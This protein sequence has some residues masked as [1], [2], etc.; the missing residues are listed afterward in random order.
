LVVLEECI[1]NPDHK[2]SPAIVGWP[3]GA[4][5]YRCRH[6]S[7]LEKHW[8]DAKTVI[9]P[10]ASRTEHKPPD[11]PLVEIM[12]S[13]R[14]LQDI[15]ADSLPAIVVHNN[16]PRTFVREGRLVRIRDVDGII[17]IEPLNESS[18]MG[19]LARSADFVQ[20][21][22]R[23]T[24]SADPP[25]KVVKDILAMTSWPDIPPIIGLVESP[26]IRPDGSVLDKFGYDPATKLYYTDEQK[27]TLNVPESLTQ[28]D[29]KKAAHWILDEVFF[30]F[31][32]KDTA[33][34]A[35]AMAALLTIIAK[36]LIDGNIPL[37]LFDKPQAGTGAGLLTEV[38]TEITT[39]KPAHLQTA[40]NSDEEWRKA[41]TSTLMN[42]PAVVVIDNVDNMLKSRSLSQKLTGRVWADRMLGQ[43]KM[44]HLPQTAACL[45]LLTTSNWVAIWHVAPIGFGKMRKR[46]DRG[47]VRD[48]NTIP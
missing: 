18:L 12:I 20:K 32:F 31:P 46:R 23:D 22:K 16:P 7:C 24:V 14:H 13:Y 40:P 38:I 42:E 5:T 25:M 6:S 15:T 3:N 45:L 8:K 39:G 36:Q 44:L 17:R 2:L 10:G 43:S 26:V 34:K 28:E 47:C 29:A 41:I 48:S 4:R 27:L 35:N 1:F 21:V 37:G 11:Q 19:I 30:D 9:E 33:S